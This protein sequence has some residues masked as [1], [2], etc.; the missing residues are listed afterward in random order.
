[1][2]IV[3]R[4]GTNQDRPLVLLHGMP[5]DSR[6]WDRVAARAPA[7]WA[8]YRVDLPGYGSASER[9]ASAL[10]DFDADVA[11]AIREAGAARPVVVAGT[12]AGAYLA[13]RACS[14]LPDQIERAVLVSGFV[15][16]AADGVKLRADLAAA[17]RGGAMTPEALFGQV[18][19]GCIPPAERDDE[20]EQY[21]RG[22]FV[23]VGAERTARLMAQ[24][25]WLVD[26]VA[27]FSTPAIVLHGKSDQFIP[28]ASAEAL[29]ALDPQAQLHPL[30]TSSHF[31]PLSHS[32]RV[33]QA[34]FGGS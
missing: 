27:P 6:T 23:D 33:A 25:A 26:A 7:G 10:A 32:E 30:E 13:A 12:S 16:L 15:E 4:T 20:A 28:F 19:D 17:L 18:V 22:L 2:P 14:R 29:A 31:L 9:E 24:A 8:V 3:D 5:G 11:A 21:L 34:V 1:M